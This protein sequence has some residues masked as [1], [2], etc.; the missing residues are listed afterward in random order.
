MEHWIEYIGLAL[1]ALISVQFSLHRR[2]NEATLSSIL[3]ELQELKW[4]LKKNEDSL[5]YR[6]PVG[7]S[8]MLSDEYLPIQNFHR[9][10]P[11]I[12]PSATQDK[13][14]PANFPNVT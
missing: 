2:R 4:Q 14:Y 13:P 3:K 1:L 11:A 6:E 12:L 5:L 9:D 10:M 8:K 7:A